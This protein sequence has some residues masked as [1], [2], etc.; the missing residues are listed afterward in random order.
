MKGQGLSEQELFDFGAN[1]GPQ[2]NWQRWPGA[3]IPWPYGGKQ[4]QVSVNIDIP[5]LQAKGLSPVD[6]INA[7][8]TQ[9]LALPSGTVK[10]GSTEFNVEMNG[11]TGHPRRAEQ[12]ADQDRERR[13]DL[14]ARMSLTSATAFRRRSISRAWTDSAACCWPVYKTGGRFHPRRRVAGLCQAAAN[15]QPPAAANW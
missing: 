4:R 11:S 14:C 12:H 8:T 1:T 5:A 2:S 15:Q 10:M 13:D 7:I 9:N 6:V 3:A